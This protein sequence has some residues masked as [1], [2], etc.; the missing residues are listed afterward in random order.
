LPGD[1]LSCP[2]RIPLPVEELFGPSLCTPG[3]SDLNQGGILA[4]DRFELLV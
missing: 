1:Q 3:A 2:K 4:E